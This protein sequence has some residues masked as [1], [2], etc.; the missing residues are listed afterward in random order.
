MELELQKA[1]LFDWLFT[2]TPLR[3]SSLTISLAALTDFGEGAAQLDMWS[4]GE[5]SPL[6]H[7][8]RAGIQAVQVGH[9]QQQIR[10]RLHRQEA[11]ARHVHAHGVAKALDSS[12]HRGLQLNDIQA[13]FQRLQRHSEIWLK[14]GKPHKLLCDQ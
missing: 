3:T 2:E 10:G 13:T 14:L 11:A 7:G 6:A 1:S 4:C 12:A 9:H 5:L 8:E